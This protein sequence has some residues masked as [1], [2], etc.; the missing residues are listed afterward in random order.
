MFDSVAR[1]ISGLNVV[2]ATLMAIFSYLVISYT[3]S[4][5]RLSHFKGPRLAS[6]SYLWMFLQWRHGRHGEAYAQVVSER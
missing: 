1:Q 4:Y 2:P 5:R 6:V 3:L